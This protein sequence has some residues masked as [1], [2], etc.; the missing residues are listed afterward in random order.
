MSSLVTE[1]ESE[2]AKV[3]GQNES[4]GTVRGDT[5]VRRGEGTDHDE[6]VEG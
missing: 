3:N 4:V 1:S 2:N 5:D 6:V